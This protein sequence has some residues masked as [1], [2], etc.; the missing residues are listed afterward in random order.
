MK[1]IGQHIW[2]FISRFRSDVYLE[3]VDSGTI[4][5]GGNLGLDSN[6]KIVKAN[7][8]DAL[9]FD[10]ST[11]NGLLTY[12]DADE[13]SVESTFT[14]NGATGL[15]T[16]NSGTSAQPN[17]SLYNN[18]T[19]EFGGVIQFVSAAVDNGS[20]DDEL[21]S[22]R[23]FGKNSGGESTRFADITAKIAD[24]TDGAEEG[25]LTLSVASH[26]GEMQSGL[27][28]Y[29]GNAE[30]EVDVDIGNGAT[31]VTTIAGDLDIDGDNMTSAGA[32]TFTPVGKYTITAPDLT[33]DVF[34]LDADADTDNVVNID[35]GA[36]DID[37][38]AATTIDAAGSITL[39]STATGGDAI[40]IDASTHGS[41]VLNIDAG[42]LDIDASAATTLD[43]TSFTVTSDDAIFTSSTASHPV[44]EIRNTTD[45]G[46]GPTLKLN[47]A[48]AS[49]ASDGGY[50]VKIT[51]NGMDDGTPTTQQY[52]NIF[53]RIDDATSTEE[54]GAMSL[55]VATHN[56]GV[57]TGLALVGGSES[58]EG[59]ATI[60]SGA[61][62]L[63]TRAGE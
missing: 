8:G 50:C 61:N 60:G 9:S 28:I 54:S 52:G 18:N 24:V 55:Q 15:T 30:D 22:L 7:T 42:A 49:D 53:V 14:Y 2:D 4:A 37:T 32:M 44:V 39:T 58:A 10:G 26:D 19:D 36:L 51:F 62:S 38:T 21:G 31:S 17:I 6:N 23:W 20:N 34:H 57:G 56:G 45:D 1:W 5:S 59:D 12:K 41:S 3:S 40:H 13:I 11:A 35:A 46:T 33:G 63:T 16:I 29:S 27:A 48:R 47:N 43:T 25:K